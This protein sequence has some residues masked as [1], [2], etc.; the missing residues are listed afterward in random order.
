[1]KKATGPF[2]LQS[3]SLSGEGKYLDGHFILK[4]SG[5]TVF[6][7]DDIQSIDQ[8]TESEAKNFVAKVGWSTAALIGLG[9]IFSGGLGLLGAGAA[10]LATG[11]DKKIS[12]LIRLNSNDQFILTVP[13]RV[14]LEIKASLL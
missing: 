7:I 5:K 9:T 3:S 8:M 14:Y 6:S 12:C 13:E 1:M 2:V 10:L 11:N 4:D